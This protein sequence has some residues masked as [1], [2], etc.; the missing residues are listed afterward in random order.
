MMFQSYKTLMAVTHMSTQKVSKADF[1]VVPLPRIPPLWSL[2]LGYKGARDI[3]Q[4]ES[5]SLKGEAGPVGG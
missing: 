3:E 1:P 2:G 5:A 4:L